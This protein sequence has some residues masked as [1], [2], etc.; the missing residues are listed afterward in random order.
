MKKI[1]KSKLN[2]RI[3]STVENDEE[4]EVAI[5]FP[6]SSEWI[7]WGKYDKETAIKKH[8]EL[9]IL[10]VKQIAFRIKYFN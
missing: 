4:Y 8:K 10:T 3:V 7:I 5:S 2:D 9:E 1:L 6:N